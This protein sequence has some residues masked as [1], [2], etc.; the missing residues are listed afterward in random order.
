M[1]IMNDITCRNLKRLKT[2]LL[3]IWK[4]NFHKIYVKEYQL[5]GFCYFIL[6]YFGFMVANSKY[7]IEPLRHF[8]KFENIMMKTQLM[9]I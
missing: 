4:W 7:F 3:F 2:S 8:R 9:K 5:E 6:F 1:Q